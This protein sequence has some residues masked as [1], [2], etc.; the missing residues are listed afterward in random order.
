M[1]WNELATKSAD[2]DAQ[3]LNQLLTETRPWLVAQ[4]TRWLQEL[5]ANVH[6]AEDIVQ[7]VQM[8][9]SRKRSVKPDEKVAGWLYTV[10][11]RTTLKAVQKTRRMRSLISTNADGEE[12]WPHEPADQ[13]GSPEDQALYKELRREVRECL[14]E[15]P[16]DLQQAI[17]LK[18]FKDLTQKQAAEA[19]EL[20]LGTFK[21]R[22]KNARERLKECLERRGVAGH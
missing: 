10:L 5:K 17:I 20:P 12:T 16:E 21:S 2:G 4:A 15:L 19:L 8:A 1:N 13:N 7:A 9:L 22:L 3:A 6:L 11:L 14:A 18:D